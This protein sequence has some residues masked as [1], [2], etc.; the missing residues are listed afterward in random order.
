MISFIYHY[1]P[2]TK[3]KWRFVS[4]GAMFATAASIIASL[5]F[6]FFV[7][8]F[9]FHNEFYGSL[10]A[11]IVLMLWLNLNALILLVGFEINHSIDANKNLKREASGHLDLANMD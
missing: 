11:L 8:N 9:N 4:P 7:N 2:A 6:S 10:G 3:R 5:V 1:G